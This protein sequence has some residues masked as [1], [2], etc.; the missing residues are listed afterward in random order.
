MCFCISIKDSNYFLAPSKIKR[1]TYW[2]ISKIE[3]NS[4]VVYERSCLR[5]MKPH[6]TNAS[7]SPSEIHMS[8]ISFVS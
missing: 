7:F 5:S 6:L 3:A 1:A 4:P 2:S 8:A